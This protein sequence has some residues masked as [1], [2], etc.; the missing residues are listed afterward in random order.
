ML[1]V[2]PFSLIKVTAILPAK[3]IER[4]ARLT[5]C[6]GMKHLVLGCKRNNFITVAKKAASMKVIS[7]P[8]SCCKSCSSG[9]NKNHTMP[10]ASTK[11]YFENITNKRLPAKVSY[12]SLIEA[13]TFEIFDGTL[14]DSSI[15]PNSFAASV[16]SA[17][18]GASKA[19][20]FSSD[21][22]YAIDIE[23]P[24]PSIERNKVA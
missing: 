18:V 1:V 16:G 17:D 24:K 23:M 10:T 14:T 5:L 9:C 12:V 7:T 6:L 22:A 13:R 8:C 11:Q 3:E 19:G 20:I 21:L 2:S 15:L 4:T